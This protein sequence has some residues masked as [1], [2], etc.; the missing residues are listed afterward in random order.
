MRHLESLSTSNT[1]E[2]QVH[3]TFAGAKGRFAHPV[4]IFS[5]VFT[6]NASITVQSFADLI[7]CCDWL[8]SILEASD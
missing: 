4:Y 7:Q 5:D 8:V 6:S 1:V 3:Y 2:I